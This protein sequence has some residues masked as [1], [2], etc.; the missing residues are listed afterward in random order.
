MDVV[1]VLISLIP[2]FSSLH[3]K[4]VIL[5]NSFSNVQHSDDNLPAGVSGGSGYI[6]EHAFVEFLAERYPGSPV[7][8]YANDVQQPLL[9]LITEH[10][11]DVVITI[12]GG[13][14]SIMRG[15]EQNYAAIAEEQFHDFK[16][17]FF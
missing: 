16:R 13:T 11:V 5:S 17:Q 8:V 1:E 3:K 6:P 14:D 12:D 10:S 9:Q 2:F 4:V 15:D 7:T